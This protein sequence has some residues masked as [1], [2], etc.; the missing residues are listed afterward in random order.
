MRVL[1]RMRGVCGGVVRFTSKHSLNKMETSSSQQRSLR[2]R[3]F[4]IS[5]RGIQQQSLGLSLSPLPYA[6]EASSCQWGLRV[7][8][9]VDGRRH[10]LRQSMLA[11]SNCRE[12]RT[13]STQPASGPAQTASGSWTGASPHPCSHHFGGVSGLADWRAAMW[14]LAFGGEQQR[15]ARRLPEA[16]RWGE[17]PGQSQGGGSCQALREGPAMPLLAPCR[18]AME[19]GVPVLPP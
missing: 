13:G 15:G 17:G 10:C 12:V 3:P 7:Y 6:A 16:P 19:G 1:T 4:S 8:W 11:S 14:C 9:D 5:L 18:G 2:W